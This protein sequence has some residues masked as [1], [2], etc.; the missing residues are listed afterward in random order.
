M[1][2]EKKTSQMNRSHHSHTYFHKHHAVLPYIL[3]PVIF[4]LIAMVVALPVGKLMLNYAINTVHKAQTQLTMGFNDMEPIETVNENNTDASSA[5]FYYGEKLGTVVCERAGLNTGVYFGINRLSMRA[6]AGLSV[7]AA[8]PGTGDTV[9][10][11]GHATTAFKALG[12][13]MIDDIIVV[14]TNWGEY[15]YKVYDIQVQ[16]NST[17]N[18]GDLVLSAPI[19][20]TPFAS[21]QQEHL[22]VYASPVSEE[23]AQ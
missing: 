7:K 9:K 21:Y 4:V 6:G 22:Y 15:S 12:Y 13:V 18:K 14:S 5:R 19:S 2:E 8:L 16:A 1:S 11:A 20:S 3:T 10:I 17:E 23:V